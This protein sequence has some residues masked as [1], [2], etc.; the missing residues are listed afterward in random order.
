MFASEGSTMMRRMERFGS[1]S[2]DGGV[3]LSTSAHV[4]VEDVPLSVFCRWPFP[5]PTQTMSELPFAIAMAVMFDQ[6][7]LSARIELHVGVGAD[8]V[9]VRQRLPP[10]ASSTVALFGS[11]TTG[12]TKL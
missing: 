11:M 3:L 4:G 9:V 12:A 6:G 5:S 1:G 10:P 7:L 2:S 8:A